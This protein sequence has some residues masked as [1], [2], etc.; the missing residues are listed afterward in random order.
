M[1]SEKARCVQPQAA[2][3]RFNEGNTIKHVLN[4]QPLTLQSNELIST[5]RSNIA[6]RLL[7]N[8]FPLATRAVVHLP[9]GQLPC[10]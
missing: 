5:S 2:N 9:R 1:P 6:L 7:H 3:L 8:T 4:H 10:A